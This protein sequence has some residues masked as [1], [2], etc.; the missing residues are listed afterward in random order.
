MKTSLILMPLCTSLLACAKP[1]PP[2][3]PQE[4]A[5]QPVTFSILGNWYDDMGDLHVF[6]EDGSVTSQ[7]FESAA[8]TAAGICTEA[9]FDVSACAEPRFLWRAHP[10]QA[11]S[12]LFAVRMPMTTGGTDEKAASCF[13]V[14]EPGLPM[15]AQAQDA[16]LTVH[17]LGSDGQVLPTGGY[18]MTRTVPEP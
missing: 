14:P 8:K 18:T 13:C 2:V 3:A 15:I 1:A 16:D 11:S 17:T 9:G 6:N 10:S 4:E 5:P 12:F 7:Q